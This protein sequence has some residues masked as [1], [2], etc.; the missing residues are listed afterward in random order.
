M[1]NTREMAMASVLSRGRRVCAAILFASAVVL[2]CID[3]LIPLF[4]YGWADDPRLAGQADPDSAFAVAWLS[5]CCLTLVGLALVAAL[6]PAGLRSS[7]GFHLLLIALGGVTV[8]CLYR[9]LEV[10]PYYSG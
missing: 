4:P 5:L 6:P 8:A 9:L 2:L 10:A 1:K 7:R 3:Y